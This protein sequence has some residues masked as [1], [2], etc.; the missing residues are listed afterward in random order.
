[1][2]ALRGGGRRDLRR[3]SAHNRRRQR[4]PRNA[5]EN[6]REQVPR[7]GQPQFF[8]MPFPNAKRSAMLCDGRVVIKR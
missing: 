5:V 3:P 7:H 1:M 4:R 6:Y 8:S 2:R